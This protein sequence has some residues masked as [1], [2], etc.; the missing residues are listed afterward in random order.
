M[1]P[2]RN[3]ASSI[4]TTCVSARSCARDLLGRVD[5]HRFDRAP[6][7]ARHVV[8]A[9][10]ALVEM[11]L[12]HLHA[13]LRDQRATHA[14]N[15]LLALPAE[16]HAADHLDPAARAA[17][18]QVAD[19]ASSRRGRGGAAERG[20]RRSAPARSYGFLAPRVERT[21]RPLRTIAARRAARSVRPRGPVAAITPRIASDR[22]ARRD[23]HRGRR[24]ARRTLLARLIHARLH[25]RPRITLPVSLPATSSAT[26]AATSTSE[27]VSRTSIFPICEPGRPADVVTAVDELLR[28][29]A[30][31]SPRLT[32]SIVIGARCAAAAAGRA[33]RCCSSMPERRRGDL[34]A[35]ELLEQRLEREHFATHVAGGEHVAQRRAQRGVLSARALGCFDERDRAHGSAAEQRAQ[36]GELRR[37]D[38]GVQLPSRRAGERAHLL[39]RRRKVEQHERIGAA[40][41]ARSL[42]TRTASRG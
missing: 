11:R 2:A 27:C 25:R 18:I 16:H 26:D 29:H 6:V 8:D 1:A 3:C 21:R 32:N 31:L 40:R 15:E 17:G 9:G 20:G 13:L 39:A 24:A 22:R 10:V 5:R 19:H 37:L 38:D 7:V 36:A 41:G 33:G 14:A 42:T 28:P 12:E 4:A 30:V 23:A 35:V 34:D